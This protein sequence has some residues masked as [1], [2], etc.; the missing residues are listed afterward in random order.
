[1]PVCSRRQPRA[2]QGQHLPRDLRGAPRQLTACR[3]CHKCHCTLHAATTGCC[4]LCDAATPAAFRLAMDRE[5]DSV[6]PL[7]SSKLLCAP[8]ESVVCGCSTLQRRTALPQR[9]LLPQKLPRPR[10]TPAR[11]RTQTCRRPRRASPRREGCCSAA[12]AAHEPCERQNNSVPWTCRLQPADPPPGLNP[13][14]LAAG[15]LAVR[16]QAAAALAADPGRLLPL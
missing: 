2:V 11:H 16:Q 5:V 7:K 8:V 6:H 1:M 13:L 12:A 9:M 4:V 15:C 10:L 14:S 3:K